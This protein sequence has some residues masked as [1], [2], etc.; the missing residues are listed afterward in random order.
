MNRPLILSAVLLLTLF[1]RAPAAPVPTH[2]MK[3]RPLA[4]ALKGKWQLTSRIENGVESDANLVKNRTL[5]FGDGKYTLYNGTEEFLTAKFTVDA[6]QKP[7][8]F[9]IP[10]PE[11]GQFGVVK[12]EGD[13]LTIC[14]GP[15]DGARATEFE[16]PKGKG[17][18]LLTY[19]R[20]R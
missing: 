13:V 18:I 19:K 2:L 9:D 15:P 1:A 5:V 17:R 6:T 4:E 20:V 14:I 7:H 16:S 8:H 3:E 12:L 11:F 10:G